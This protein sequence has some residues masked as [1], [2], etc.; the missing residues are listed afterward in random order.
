MPARPSNLPPLSGSAPARY[1]S[2]V[3]LL[4]FGSG[5]AA[6]IY[7]VVWLQLLS[8]VIGS[9]AVSLGVLLG[10][11]MGGMCVG[12]IA[13]SR[14]VSARDHPL[15]VYALLEVGISLFAILILGGLPYAGG[16]YTSIGGSGALGLL[17]RAIFSGLCLLPPTMLMGAT[18]PAMSRWVEATPRGMSWLGLFYGAN[19]V[20]AVLGCILSG[21]YLLR[22][23]DM[24]VATW[25]AV[26]INGLVALGAY[27]LSMT[28][29]HG[30]RETEPPAGSDLSPA[31]S[32][33]VFMAIGVSGMTA[34]AA[35]VVWTRLLSLLLGATVYTFSLILAVFLIG[36]GMGS[37]V[38]AV[39]TRTLEQARRALGLCQCLLVLAILWSAYSLARALPYWPIDPS[40]ASKPI[41]RF[42]V[43]FVRCLWVVL[44]ASCLWGASF[45]LALASIA[46]GKQDLGRLVGRVY[47]ANTV[48]GIVGAVLASLYLIPSLGTQHAQRLLITL[49]GLAAAIVLVPVRSPSTG[50]VEYSWRRVLPAAAGMALLRWLTTAVPSLPPELVAWGHNLATLRGQYGDI[51]FVGE[52]MNSSMAVSRF[53]GTLNY[54]NAGKVQA[55]SLPVDMRLQRML[56]HLA[57]LVPEH[58]RDVL[59]IACGAGVTAGSVSIDPAVERETIAEIESLVPLKVAPYFKVQNFDVVHNPKV[60]IEVDDARH[61]LLTTK[62]T[63]DAITSDPFDPWVKGAASLY[64][65]EFFELMKAH[66]NPGGVVTIFVQLYESGEDA[67]KSEVATFISA[68]P[69]GVVFGNT[70][71]GGGYDV[72]LLGRA[73]PAPIDVD[74][75]ERRLSRPE[76][77]PVRQ[78]LREIGFASATQLF[79]TFAAKGSQLQLWL[80]DAQVN[81]DRNLRLQYL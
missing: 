55:S 43:D 42:E 1:F 70:N 47:A 9:S 38:G 16:L 53:G 54:H 50:A 77:A 72:V 4:F 41:Y 33:P 5:C 46:P 65:K 45:P 20:G 8:L 68:F 80:K 36:L 71:N 35:E 59:V 78:S 52:G 39:A 31:G 10:T 34:L 29:P 57:T 25:V 14:L 62:E 15:R 12:S 23:H 2:I 49:S 73:D 27:L 19:T 32:L 81:R 58:A 13:F 40:L 24:T 76:Y 79:S 60:R 28:S 18:L 51:L 61:F 66:L 21:Y 56:G 17:I 63:F 37:G 67:V 3:L 7:E 69:N 64:T 44:P 22:V 6:L 48:G 11:Y 74:D 26:A 30:A 75:I